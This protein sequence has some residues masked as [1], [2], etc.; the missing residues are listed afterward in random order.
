MSA[1]AAAPAQVIT[2]MPVLTNR[3][4]HLHHRTL[5]VFNHGSSTRWKP[6][7]RCFLTACSQRAAPSWQ[8]R[9]EV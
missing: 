1:A 8:C 4:M 7:T 5:N 3:C 2:C 9:E 6:T